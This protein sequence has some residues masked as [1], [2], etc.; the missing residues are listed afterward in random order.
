MPG[1]EE[2]ME[3]VQEGQEEA[4]P[5]PE[6]VTADQMQ[7]MINEA[8]GG[9]MQNLQGLVQPGVQPAGQPVQPKAVELPPE[10]SDDDIAAAYEE[11]DFK[12]AMKL[13]KQQRERDRVA[14]QQELNQLRMD[15]AAAIGQIGEEVLVSKLPD[16][17]KYK[18]EIDEYLL[19]FPAES[20]QD[21]G[22]RREV[23][24]LIRGKHADD[25]ANERVEE[26]K[27]QQNLQSGTEP[28][29]T[30]G[31]ETTTKKATK[32]AV[33]AQFHEVDLEALRTVGRSSDEF[34]RRLGYESME[35]YAAKAAE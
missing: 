31:R 27:R 34:A 35:D 9:I 3:E 29:S 33:A 11:G 12:R 1:A 13:Q 26:W 22:V 14:H 23:Y 24:F 5:Q 20:R 6:Y 15:G 21:P 2:E 17:A 32:S 19:Q 18:K 8:V 10:V 30:T 25:I 4:E 7:S 28:G 16:Y